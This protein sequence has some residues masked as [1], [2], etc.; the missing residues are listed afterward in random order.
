MSG[1]A[2][3]HDCWFSGIHGPEER[4][5]GVEHRTQAHAFLPPGPPLHH[6][7]SAQARPE[8]EMEPVLAGVPGS[9]HRDE[10]EV[11]SACSED[12]GFQTGLF[13]GG[14]LSAVPAQRMDQ[15]A[16]SGHDA[17]DA[18]PAAA[19]VVE[20][21]RRAD[22]E[23]RVRCR[24]WLLQA[25]KAQCKHLGDAADYSRPA[26]LGGS[27]CSAAQAAYPP[28]RASSTARSADWPL[29]SST[30]SQACQDTGAVP[31]SIDGCQASSIEECVVVIRIEHLMR[32]AA[33]W[34]HLT[35]AHQGD[36]DDDG[37][38]L[39]SGCRD[40]GSHFAAVLLRVLS[41]TTSHAC[42]GSGDVALTW[43]CTGWK[44]IAADLAI[45]GIHLACRCL[46]RAD[47][48]GFSKRRSLVQ[49]DLHT[50]L[51]AAG[52]TCNT[53]VQHVTCNMSVRVHRHC[54]PLAL[55][56]SPD[57]EARD[58]EARDPQDADAATSQEAVVDTFKHPAK[59]DGA[60][61]DHHSPLV[62]EHQQLGQHV[63]LHSL[64]PEQRC[65]R[66]HDHDHLHPSPPETAES[67]SSIARQ[68]AGVAGFGE[69]SLS[70]RECTVATALENAR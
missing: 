34:A 32:Q 40:L 12:E 25:W 50:R 22:A 44:L 49:E 37:P 2:P 29:A 67:T 69:P 60:A 30:C 13:Q 7:H 19:R 57:P 26:L 58:T 20:T 64:H 62:S 10:D 53:S 23:P 33:G 56:F 24:G 36:A 4:T 28:V 70:T 27:P 59:A 48:Q 55:C 39:T 38:C 63:T 41:D 46:K 21:A 18:Q 35:K 43:R 5:R 66:G 14:Q 65:A 47:A 6:A 15:H 11:E 61:G 8:A 16:G 54:S 51:K 42:Q 31:S 52:A 45:A 1:R 17:R 68:D 3:P 9:A